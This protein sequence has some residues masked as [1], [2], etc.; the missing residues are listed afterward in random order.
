MFVCSSDY[1]PE[2]HYV[3]EEVSADRRSL[4]ESDEEVEEA[5]L[6]QKTKSRLNQIKSPQILIED[7]FSDPSWK[8]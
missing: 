6:R 7:Y 5:Y 8:C 4:S 1:L 3:F 2:E